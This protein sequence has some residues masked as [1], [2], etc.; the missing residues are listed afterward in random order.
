VEAVIRVVIG[1]TVK[2][3]VGAAIT[4]TSIHFVICNN[5]SF[6]AHVDFLSV[7]FLVMNAGYSS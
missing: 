2:N 7:T 4:Y 1:A 5:N 3:S 6:A